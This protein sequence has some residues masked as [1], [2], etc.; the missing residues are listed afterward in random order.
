MYEH[1]LSAPF[2][3]ADNKHK[4][5]RSVSRFRVGVSARN[6]VPKKNSRPSFRAQRFWSVSCLN[7]WII[8]AML[9]FTFCMLEDFN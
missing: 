9:Q 7:I 2:V 3:S 6:V 4:S 8:I 5:N 1:F